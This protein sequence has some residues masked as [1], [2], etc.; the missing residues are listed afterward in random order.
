MSSGTID[1]RFA[2]G[3]RILRAETYDTLGYDRGDGVI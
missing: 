3:G 2:G 1:G